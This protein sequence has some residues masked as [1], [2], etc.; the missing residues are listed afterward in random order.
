M[1]VSGKAAYYTFGELKMWKRCLRLIGE[2][3]DEDGNFKS[4]VPSEDSFMKLIDQNLIETSV[5]FVK[6]A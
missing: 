4:V 6:N 1:H 2:G 5:W 3:V